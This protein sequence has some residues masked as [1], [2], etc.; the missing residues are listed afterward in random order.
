MTFPID[1]SKEGY[2][3]FQVQLDP[4]TKSVLKGTNGQIIAP[5][6]IEPTITGGYMK[7]TSVVPITKLTQLLASLQVRDTVTPPPGPPMARGVL[8][9]PPSPL[10][11]AKIFVGRCAPV[12]VDRNATFSYTIFVGNLTDLPLSLGTIEMYVPKG[13]DYVDA[14]LYKFNIPGA[15]FPDAGG[16]FNIAPVK[17][18]VAGKGTKVTWNIGSF[19]GREGGAVTLT[20]KVRDDF[21]GTRIDD[22]T[23]VFDV[24][25][26]C[27]KTPGPIGVIVRAGNEQT[28]SSEIVGSAASGLGVSSSTDVTNALMQ[29]FTLDASSC[30]ITTGG[31]DLLQL[32]NGVAVIQLG[33]GRVMTVGPPDKIVASGIRLVKDDAMMRI[34]VGPGDSSGVRLTKIPTL[35]PS[36]V[37]PTNTL[38]ANLHIAGSSIVGAHGG[39][40]VAAGGGNMV[41]AGGGNL[42]GLDGSTLTGPNGAKLIGNDGSTFTNVAPLVAAGGGNLIGNAGGALVAAGGGNMVAAGGG[43]IVA[44]GAGHLIGNDGST[45]SPLVAAGGGN[46]VAQDGSRLVAAGGGNLVAAGG[47]NLVA[48]GGLN[49]IVNPK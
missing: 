46:L 2:A 14:S 3:V 40:M 37:Q 45:I 22:N 12:F 33:S 6:R 5:L 35:S 23:C 13:C 28:Q 32:N 24:V 25:N 42:I 47:G 30:S 19:A 48:A 36:L 26:A 7:G 11:D 9:P 31:T 21:S 1:F 4:A 8:S 16:T 38:L 10:A 43:N 17:T 41:A 15:A 29:D 18:V 27:G 34:A 20:V 44:A 49:L 39:N